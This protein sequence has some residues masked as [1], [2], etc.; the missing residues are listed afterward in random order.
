MTSN[1]IKLRKANTAKKDE[2][3]TQLSDIERELKNYQKH[4]AGKTILCN[5]DDPRIS[6][7]FHY[8][9]Y[10]FKKLKL[11]KLITT[12]YKSQ[13]MDLFSQNDS[14]Q[15]IYLEYKGDKNKIPDPN[16]IGICHLKKNGD[17]R[18]DECIKIL[19]RSDIVITNPPFSL[20]REYV[21]QLMTYKKKFI[22]IGHQ[23]A[24]SYKEIFKLL[25]KNKMWLGYG[26]A[27][28]ATHFMTNYEDKAISGNHKKG[29]VR[30]SGVNWFTNLDIVKRHQ[31]LICHKTYNSEEYP[32]LD[33]YDAINV[34]KTNDIPIDYKG[35]MAVPIT[36]MTKYNPSQFTIIDGI[37]R[38]SFLDGP[39]DKTRGKY[40]TQ[41]GDKRIYAR[42]VIKHKKA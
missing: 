41:L 27:G 20:F 33:N 21:E 40:L 3:Y 2:F 42:I 30:V 25:K 17:F 10:N 1:N 23:N 13:Q 18:N 28:G 15:A 11:K 31:D 26:F 6:K 32:T 38:Y 12:C 24:I 39:T 36:F 19:K 29:M 8:F 14:K 5:C 7:F 34:N 35:A 9:S 22:I 37:G 16:K 4:F